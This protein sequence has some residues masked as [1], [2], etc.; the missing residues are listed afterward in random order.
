[1]PVFRPRAKAKPAARRRR[2]ASLPPAERARI[3]RRF[4]QAVNLSPAAL[5]AHLSTASS[6]SVGFRPPGASTSVGRRSGFVIL[7]LLQKG[8]HSDADYRHMRKV[9]GYVA[10]HLAQRPAA[11]VRDSRWRASLMNWGHD[12]LGGR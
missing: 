9:A 7:R 11:G 1:M 6:R 12:P 3:E 10:R 4:R 2:P 5:A 8:P